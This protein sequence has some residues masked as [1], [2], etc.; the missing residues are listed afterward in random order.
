MNP[1]QAAVE[2]LAQVRERVAMSDEE[3]KALT[4][5]EAI[6]EGELDVVI[7]GQRKKIKAY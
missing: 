7:A 1:Y 5:H 2:Q 6:I 4:E 3:W